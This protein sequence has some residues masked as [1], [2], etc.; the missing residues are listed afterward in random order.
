MRD[1]AAAMNCDASYATGIVDESN[2]SASP[3]D[4]QPPWT[5]G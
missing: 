1:L 4:G 2:A 3:R 5:G